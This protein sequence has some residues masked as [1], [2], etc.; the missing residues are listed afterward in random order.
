MAAITENEA[1]VAVPSPI[2]EGSPALDE[3]EAS[4]DESKGSTSAAVG[5]EVASNSLVDAFANLTVDTIPELEQVFNKLVADHPVAKGKEASTADRNA[6]EL[7]KTTLVYGEITFRSY[8][9]AFEKIKNKYGGLQNPG[10][11]FYDLGSG[12]GKPVLSAALLHD[13]DQVK[14]IELLESLHNIALE[15]QQVWESSIRPTLS[16]RK[17]KTG[18]LRGNMSRAVQPCLFCAASIAARE[19][20][21]W[22]IAR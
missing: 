4:T 13:F 11:V 22:C 1:E 14:G 10:G 3:T 12:T 7:K 9:I 5:D 18:K 16:E 6:L 2:L 21:V 17:Q 8:A 15:L 19:D 20:F